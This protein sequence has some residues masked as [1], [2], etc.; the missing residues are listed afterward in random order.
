MQ[1]TND[2]DEQTRVLYEA[3]KHKDNLLFLRVEIHYY[4]LN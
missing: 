2:H 1:G 3:G 4:I